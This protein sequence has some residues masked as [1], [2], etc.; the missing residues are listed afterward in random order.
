MYSDPFNSPIFGRP[1]QFGGPV[2]PSRTR[3]WMSFCWSI[4]IPQCALNNNYF[5]VH[6]SVGQ[7][8]GQGGWGKVMA[9]LCSKCCQLGIL[10]WVVRDK[11]AWLTQLRF[12]GNGCQVECLNTPPCVLSPPPG[13]LAPHG[14]FVCQNTGLHYMARGQKRKLPCLFTPA[15]EAPQLPFCHIFLVSASHRA[16]WG[17]SMGDRPHPLVDKASN[18]HWEEHKGWEALMWWS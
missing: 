2:S 3:G 9:S 4:A 17:S 10:T 16:S 13:L 7:G 14:L 6:C 15:S 5:I 18:S 8:F 1:S 12:F 11:M